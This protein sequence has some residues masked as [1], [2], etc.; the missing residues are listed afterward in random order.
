MQQPEY[1]AAKPY[2]NPEDAI[3]E[4]RIAAS[5]KKSK[6]GGGEGEVVGVMAKKEKDVASVAVAEDGAGAAGAAP[7]ERPTTYVPSELPDRYA[8]LSVSK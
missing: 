3:V 4:I 6:T 1:T 7:N 5:T 2:V 8:F